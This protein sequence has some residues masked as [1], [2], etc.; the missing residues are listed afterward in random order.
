MAGKLLCHKELWRL[1]RDF[2]VN[3]QKNS[4]EI[5]IST[6][7]TEGKGTEIPSSDVIGPL[8]KMR[9]HNINARYNGEDRFVLQTVALFLL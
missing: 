6:E 3:L 5:R 1:M 9:R 4:N 8:F 2:N 7:K